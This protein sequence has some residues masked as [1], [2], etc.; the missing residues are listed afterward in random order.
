M[1]AI[2]HDY[3]LVDKLE[4]WTLL[5]MYKDTRFHMLPLEDRAKLRL[6]TM[7]EDDSSVAHKQPSLLEHFSH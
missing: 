4:A 6:H 5:I 2:A 3:S 7:P 1:V